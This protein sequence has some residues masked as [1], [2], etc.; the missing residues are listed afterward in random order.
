MKYILGIDQSTQGT[1]CILFDSLGKMVDK[2]Q[3]FHKQIINEKSWISHDPE[4]I[5]QGMLQ[6]IR[7]LIQKASINTQDIVA[8]SICN[9]RETALIWD[10]EGRALANAVVWQCIRAKDICSELEKSG[11]ANDILQR[12]G[13]KLSPYFSAAK[14]T[15][16]LKNTNIKQEMIQNQS[17]KIGTMD[18]FLLYRLSHGQCYATDYSNASRTQLYNIHTLSWDPILCQYFQIPIECLPEVRDSNSLFTFSDFEGIFDKEIPIHAVLGDS[19]AALFAQGCNSLDTAKVTY[20]TGSSIVLNT[21]NKPVQSD[22]GLSTSIGWGI[23]GTIDYI[24]E[25]NITN[26]ASVIS[27]LMDDI[28]LIS[29]IDEANILPTSASPDDR[30]VLVPAFTGLG[31]PYWDISARAAFLGMSRTTGKAEMVKATVESIAFQV[32]DV[33]QIM[34]KNVGNRIS[35]L[36]VDG[37]PTRNV[38]LMDFQS[39]LSDV[40]IIIPAISELSCFGSAK[41]AMHSLGYQNFSLANN[42]T[43]DKKNTF[44]RI[45]SQENEELRKM[46]RH[47]WSDACMRVRSSR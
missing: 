9:Q 34:E 40:E 22:S 8:A 3:V 44:K 11:Y 36:K 25:G 46:W 27:W 39:K 41:L 24:L 38:Y 18:S 47:K 43:N 23:N 7:S 13:L 20:G 5:Y 12:S 6:A 2:S 15:W 45:N 37:A 29:S 16:L 33:I 30:T 19:Q 4:E 10:S 42:E 26:S 21:G 28:G 32:D 31:A 35:V 1:K 14:F 17:V